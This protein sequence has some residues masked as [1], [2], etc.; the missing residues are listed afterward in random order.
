MPTSHPHHMDLD[1]P[2][3]CPISSYGH[4]TFKDG[5]SIL[6]PCMLL[7]GCKE[8]RYHCWHAGY[9]GRD[10]TSLFSTLGHKWPQLTNS[11]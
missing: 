9:L 5:V 4:H 8:S 10:V 3:T 7:E 1:Y 6:L 2:G 11:V